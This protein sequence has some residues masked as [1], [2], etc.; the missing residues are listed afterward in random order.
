MKL[1]DNCT[2]NFEKSNIIIEL[3]PNIITTDFRLQMQ[4]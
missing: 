1:E 3:I 2:I 4:R